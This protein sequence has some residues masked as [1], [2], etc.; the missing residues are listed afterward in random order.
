M[1]DEVKVFTAP[2]GEQLY[3]FSRTGPGWARIFITDKGQFIAASDYGGFE[4][5]WGSVGGDPERSYLIRTLAF[6]ADVEKD[7]G[8]FIRKLCYGKKDLYDGDQT[9]KEIKKHIIEY[10]RDG[11]YTK[12]EARDLWNEFDYYDIEG[13][14]YDFNR[15]VDLGLIDEAWEFRCQKPDPD[16]VAFVERVMVKWLAPLIRK[17]V[18]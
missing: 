15:W 9:L 13:E 7:P 4:H 18:L 12:D 5:W 14:E 17:Q 16:T 3:Q 2:D 1:S 10:R 6:I 11:S 8:Y